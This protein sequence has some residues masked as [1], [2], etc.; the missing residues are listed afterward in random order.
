MYI[1]HFKKVF[2]TQS[3]VYSMKKEVRI[4]VYAI[5][6]LA[7]LAFMVYYLNFSPTGFAVLSQ[8]TTES[9]CVANNY[10]WENLTEQNCTIITNCVNT[11]IDC[12]PCLEYEDLN[13]TQ[14]ECLTWSSCPEENCTDTQ[15]CVDIIVGGRCVGDICDSSHLSL[16][17]SETTCTGASGHWYNSICNEDECDSNE[18]CD[19]GYE[20]SVGNC[21]EIVEE[22]NVTNTTVTEP[23]P[24]LIVETPRVTQISIGEISAQNLNQGDSK[25]LTLSVQNT[26]TEPVSS[27]V[28]TGDD[29]GFVSIAGNEAMGINAGESAVYSFSLN[30]PKN[31]NLGAHTVTLSVTCAEIG[32]SK[33]VAVNVLQKKLDFNITNVQRTREDRV[34]VNY[35]LT[36]LSGEKQDVQILFTI[37]DVSGLQVANMSQNKSIGANKTDDFSV[38]IPINKSLEGNLTLSAAFNSQ[39]YSSTVLE[40]ISLGA[41]IGGFAIFEGIGGTGSI[42][43]LVAVVLIIAVIFFIAR[44]MRK[45]AKR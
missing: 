30:I 10:S 8:Y 6:V 4:S 26:G 24:E 34:R 9:S 5:I 12:E 25:S 41:P 32:A 20:C 19:S 40:P 18:Q 33:E 17:L 35:A 29:S 7:A 39:I 16:C 31:A 38:N 44:R 27:C 43:L 1:L 45:S 2:K 14:G 21:V 36:E 15:E 42:I 3:Y 13:G 28:L 37:K 23:I 11:T 22:T